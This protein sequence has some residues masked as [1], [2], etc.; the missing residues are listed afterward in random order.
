MDDNQAKGIVIHFLAAQLANQEGACLGFVVMPDHVH[1]LVHF[2]KEGRL[3]LFMNQW[4]RR[5]SIRL[6]ELYRNILPSYCQTI[7]LDGPM[8]QPKYYAFN[9]YSEN[10]AREKLVYMHNNPVKAGLVQSAQDWPHSSARWYLRKDAV[11]V[12]IGWPI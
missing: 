7:D 6:K 3:S 10:K 9:I 2:S 4:K 5:S 8:W 1:G 12:P 11:G